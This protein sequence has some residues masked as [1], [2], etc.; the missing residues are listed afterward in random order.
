MCLAGDDV[1]VARGVRYF[2]FPSSLYR[3]ANMLKL[4]LSAL[5]VSTLAALAGPASA[6]QATTPPAAPAQSASSQSKSPEGAY[7]YFVNLKNGD[8]VTSP[9]KVVFGL[10]PNMSV[11]PSGVDKPNVG[12]HHLL[13]D[14]T[15]SSE[16][17]TQPIT[18]DEQH[19]HFG[20]GQTETM[21][22]LP[23]GKHTLQLVL[24]D[25]THIPF[26]PPVQSEVIT[27][28]VKGWWCISCSAIAFAGFAAAALPAK[29]TT[30]IT[31][32]S[33]LMRRPCAGRLCSTGMSRPV[34]PSQSFQRGL[35]EDIRFASE[36]L[37]VAMPRMSKP[38]GKPLP[39]RTAFTAEPPSRLALNWAH[40]LGP[41]F[42]D[43]SFAD[44]EVAARKLM[45]IANSVEPVQDGRIH[46]R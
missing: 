2:H 12:H 10:T 16:E 33:D 23:P 44:P 46:V 38:P 9:F 8:V 3:E 32:I 29:I 41:G 37:A 19:V 4:C 36:A 13:I 27:I 39:T 21:V 26:N 45:E 24:G 35:V 43:R 25:W 40:D 30:N 17:I 7:S 6:Q 22:T 14:K 28:T 11:A 1:R 15:L 31:N 42:S 34:L 18:V 5:T 20:K